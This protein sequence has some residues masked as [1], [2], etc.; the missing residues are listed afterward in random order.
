MGLNDDNNLLE[1]LAALFTIVAGCIALFVFMTGKQNVP[2]IF[3]QPPAQDPPTE[4]PA[5]TKPPLAA[6]PLTPVQTAV[7]SL[8]P[9][10]SLYFCDRP[11]EKPSAF[12]TER[13]KENEHIYATWTF[14]GLANGTPYKLIWYVNRV[15]WAKSNCV[16]HGSSAGTQSITIDNEDKIGGD[17][18]L[19]IEVSGHPTI[20]ATVSVPGF[21][22]HI[23]PIG[24]K[25][26]PDF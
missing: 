2:E 8:S 4:M 16:L 24:E 17:W 7:K 9:I 23:T 12:R 18:T 26:C 13:A 21:Y 15:E 20:S 5:F 14:Q 1:T 3:P 6:R 10:Y 22:S 19:S 11:C 25:P